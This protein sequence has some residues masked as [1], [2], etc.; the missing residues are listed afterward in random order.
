MSNYVNVLGV[1]QVNYTNKDGR[2][3]SGVRIHYTTEGNKYV[4]GLI[5]ENQYISS[6]LLQNNEI[7]HVGD[8]VRFYYNR[9]GSVDGWE[10]K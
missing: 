2:S 6:Q 1:Q 4:E 9:Y 10:V 3:V 7:I 5:C 8:Q